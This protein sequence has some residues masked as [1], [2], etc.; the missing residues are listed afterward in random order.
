VSCLGSTR[1]RNS[2]CSPNVPVGV[3]D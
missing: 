3:T 2:V 1:P